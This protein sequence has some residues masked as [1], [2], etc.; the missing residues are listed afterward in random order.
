MQV[1]KQSKKFVPFNQLLYFV[2]RLCKNA[3]NKRRHLHNTCAD[4]RQ[5]QGTLDGS[6]QEAIKVLPFLTQASFCPGKRT[7]F[8]LEYSAQLELLKN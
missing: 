3:F 6:H 7:N 8:W 2:G 4:H 5:R 1:D